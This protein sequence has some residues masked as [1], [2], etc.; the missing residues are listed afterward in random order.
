MAR[1]EFKPDL[2]QPF[3][4]LKERGLR[5]A[6]PCIT[7]DQRAVIE[8][9]IR[10]QDGQRTTTI[11]LDYFPDEAEVQSAV[12][13]LK[14]DKHHPNPR[15]RIEET[16]RETGIPSV[17]IEDWCA[18]PDFKKALFA[19]R[20]RAIFFAPKSQGQE[21][22]NRA[23]DWTEPVY[24]YESEREFIERMVAQ[25]TELARRFYGEQTRKGLVPTRDRR[26]VEL[27][28]GGWTLTRIQENDPDAPQFTQ[29]A[30]WK[31]IRKEAK[32]Y[33]IELRPGNRGPRRNTRKN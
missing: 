5:A 13:R 16:A 19:A 10:S 28:N 21:D 25:T 2:N 20:Q 29:P 17:K 4:A 26:W 9:M 22:R 23:V 32:E 24:T 11:P 14:A 6:P 31:A 30:I 7:K 12:E 18:E 3:P 15:T 33:N 1:D 27:W 8:C